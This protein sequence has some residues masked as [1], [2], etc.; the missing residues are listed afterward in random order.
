MTITVLELKQGRARKGE[1]NAS[2]RI[3]GEH[4][5]DNSAR[6]GRAFGDR[7]LRSGENDT[8]PGDVIAHQAVDRDWQALIV[9]P[10]GTAH[11]VRPNADD[12][13]DWYPSSRF[14]SFKREIKRLISCDLRAELERLLA[15]ARQRVEAKRADIEQ[16]R[17]SNLPASVSHAERELQP[18]EK[19][20]ADL[21]ADITALAGPDPDALR[22]ERDRL[23]ARIA[24]IDALLAE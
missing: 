24:E 19:S 22:A 5:L 18:L 17:E 6:D 14:A 8:T 1:K 15:I 10:T 4:D 12:F 11:R 23:V 3:V 20:V 16:W 2:A 7:W 9:G 21:E 13:A